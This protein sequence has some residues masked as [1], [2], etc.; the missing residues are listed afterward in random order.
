[1]S[2]TIRTY[3]PADEIARNHAAQDEAAKVEFTKHVVPRR[4]PP[5]CEF[6]GGTIGHCEHTGGILP[7]RR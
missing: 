2:V 5:K 6:C 3:T 1:M 4:A 7:Y